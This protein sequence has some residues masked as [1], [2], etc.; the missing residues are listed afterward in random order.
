MSRVERI[1]AALE[2]AFAPER[3]EVEDDSH[4]HAGHAGARDGRGHFNV[5]IVSPAFAGMLPLARHR[6]VYAALGTMMETDIHAL[7]I[8]AEPPPA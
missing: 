6:A 4:R 3:L 1:R 2:A 7:S 8:R 5:T